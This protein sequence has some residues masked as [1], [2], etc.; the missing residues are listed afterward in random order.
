MSSCFANKVMARLGRLAIVG[1]YLGSFIS[2]KATR[3]HT[4][5][6]II[7]NWLVACYYPG[8]ELNY[9]TF[10]ESLSDIEPYKRLAL[11]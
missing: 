3:L 11:T 5:T 6:C 8:L 4:N 2:T 7:W 10:V 1:S 9:V